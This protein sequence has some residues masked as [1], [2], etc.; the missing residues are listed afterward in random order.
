MSSK[1]QITTRNR[2]LSR[3][4]SHQMFSFGKDD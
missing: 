2:Q 4:L 1:K 3:S